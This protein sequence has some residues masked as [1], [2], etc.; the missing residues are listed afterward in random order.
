VT[1]QADEQPVG[2]S[3]SGGVS[4]LYP[5]AK[6][7]AG[8]MPRP[9]RFAVF[10][11]DTEDEHEWTY[12]AFERVAELCKVHGID[13]VLG[14]RRT[15]YRSSPKKALWDDV[16]KAA[17]GHFKRVD[18]PPLWT[19]NQGGGR[20]QLTQQ[21][22]QVYKTRVVRKLQA[23]WLEANKLPKKIT[24]WIGYG[25]DEQHRANKAI[26]NRDVKWVDLD[27]PAIRV[28]ASRGEQ[29][30][31]V[32][33][34]LGWSPRFSMC[35]RCP[36]KD[37]ER[38]RQTPE[39]DLAAVFYT[40]EQIRHGLEHVGVDEPCYLTDRLIPVEQLI[41]RGDPQ[42]SLPGFEPPGCDSGAC[43]L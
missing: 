38:W 21:C 5:L 33:R 30:A 31:D 34:I 7:I 2:L 29:R 1:P 14:S 20:G 37:P 18:T 17:A 41:R 11:A 32:E 13:F 26:A 10:T 25:R 40:D 12:E 19:E 35:R 42:P 27:F 39:K 9:K 43:F 28:G 16:N 8:E 3:F 15:E 36:Y 4:S 23:Q 22:S 6:I 24:T